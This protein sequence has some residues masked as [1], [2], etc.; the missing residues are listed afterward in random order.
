VLS[1]FFALVLAA[2]SLLPAM[3]GFA[4]FLWTLLGPLL[5]LVMMAL[6]LKFARDGERTSARRL[7]LYTLLYLPVSLLVLALA[8][9][10]RP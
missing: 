1:A 4:N 7:F 9:R 6:A 5:A 8:W 3:L 2:W 10:I